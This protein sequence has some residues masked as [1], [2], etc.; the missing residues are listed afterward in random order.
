MTDPRTSNTVLVTFPETGVAMVTLHRPNATNALSLELQQ[1][2]SAHFTDLSL[3]EEVRCIV[4]T[5]G[6]S[7]FA[8]G[9][10]IHSLLEADPTV[11]HKRHTERLWG[12]IQ[13]CP[14]PVIAAIN[15]YAYG[16]VNLQ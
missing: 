6:D 7:V 15:G 8:A 11:I 13:H 14:K 10:D 5:G 12:P 16:M 9:G 2:L 4:L 1:A 3:N